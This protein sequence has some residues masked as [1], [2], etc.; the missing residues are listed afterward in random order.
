MPT[1]L[2]WLDLECPVQCDGQ[3]L[4]P[5]IQKGT[6]TGHW[7]EEAHWEYDFRNIPAGEALEQ[8][9]GLSPHQCTLNVIR[10]ARYKYVHFTN[11]PALFFDLVADPGELN[12][13]I[14]HPDYQGLVLSFAQKMLS[15]R[16]N[17]DEQTLT[18]LALTD[19]GIVSRPSPRYAPLRSTS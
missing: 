14:D 8:R 6:P 10:S 17:H 7:R 18:H 12:N 13:L 9:L 5:L 4:R 1:I 11:L 15:W 16:M 3:S 19:E 2:D